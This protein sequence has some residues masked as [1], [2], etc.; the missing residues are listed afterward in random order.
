MTSGLLIGLQPVLLT[1]IVFKKT[2][3]PN[4]LIAATS[5]KGTGFYALPKVTTGSGMSFANKFG[6]VNQER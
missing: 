3:E 5:G 2:Q 4:I 6:M 1:T